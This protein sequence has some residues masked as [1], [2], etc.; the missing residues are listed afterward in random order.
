[1]SEINEMSVGLASMTGPDCRFRNSGSHRNSPFLP[2]P[3]QSIS[4]LS[5]LSEQSE[6]QINELQEAL[7]GA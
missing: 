1:M 4:R 7:F 5:T 2:L 3:R 6:S